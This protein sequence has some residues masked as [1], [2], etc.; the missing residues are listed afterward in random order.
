MQIYLNIIEIYR[1]WDG[2]NLNCPFF[3]VLCLSSVAFAGYGVAAQAGQ[4]QAFGG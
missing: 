3:Q 4:A 2:K 1:S